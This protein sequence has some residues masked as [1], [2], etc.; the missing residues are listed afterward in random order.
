MTRFRLTI[1][2][3]GRP[4]MGWQRQDHGPTVQ[5]AVEAAL[6]VI[7]EH[8][9]VYGCG[10]TD[11]GVHATG[12]VA[13]VDIDRA[14]TAFRL[15]A[16]L[17]AG[18][19]PLPIAIVDCAETTP[20][21]HARFDC[22][23]RRYSYRIVNRRAPL[24]IDAGLAW[25]VPLPLDVDAMHAAAQRLV[26]R[27]DFTTFRSARCQSASP[28]KTLDRLDVARVG[29]EVRFDVRARSF[30]HHQ[31]RSMVGCLKLVGEGRWDEA[32]LARA[33]AAADRTAL[34]F[35]APPG[36]LVFVEA[37]YPA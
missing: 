23:G 5:S 12:Q 24:T 4:F 32:Q 26:G 37:T 27:H 28:V 35:N 11:A 21:F 9:A 33:L 8:G 7:G 30:L 36:G 31:V 13:H 2:Y 14:V 15:M 19:R 25:Q 22:T 6:A 1:E 20:A 17:N 34:G 29:N 10:R 16:A 18:L 3:D